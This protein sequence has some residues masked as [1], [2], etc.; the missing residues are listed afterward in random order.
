M[1]CTTESDAPDNL[2][3]FSVYIHICTKESNDPRNVIYV[4]K[5]FM[6]RLLSA[7]KHIPNLHRVMLSQNILRADTIVWHIL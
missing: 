3:L 1:E 5:K 4:Q 6:V 7:S 2:S